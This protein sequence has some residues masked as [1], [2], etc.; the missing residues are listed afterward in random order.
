MSQTSE[1]DFKQLVD[2]IRQGG[3]VNQLTSN[4]T[5]EQVIQ[6]RKWLNPYGRAP[7]ATAGKEADMPQVIVSL[8]NL[9][10]QYMKRFLMTSLIGF[11]Y[12]MLDEWELS[13]DEPVVPLDDFN[14]YMKTAKEAAKDG[15]AS[16]KWLADNPEPSLP[17]PDDPAAQELKQQHDKWHAE[18]LRHR[19]IIER[20]SGYSR[21]IVAR[22][23]IDYL[24]QFNPDLHVRSAYASNPLDPERAPIS[25]VTPKVPLSENDEKIEED[26]SKAF[27]AFKA[28]KTP[29]TP[30]SSHSTRHIPPADVFHRWTYYSDNNFEEIRSAVTDIYADKP[31]FEYAVLPYGEF[32]NKEEADKFVNKHRDEVIADL[33]TLTKGKWNLMGAFKANRERINFYNDKTAVVE[34]LLKQVEED[35]KLG[36]DLMRKRVER[37]KKKNIAEYGPDDAEFLERYRKDQANNQAEQMG[38]EDVARV[39]VKSKETHTFAVHEECPY[40]A[41]QVDVFDMMD[42]GKTVKKSEFFTQAETPQVPDRAECKN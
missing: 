8:I 28:S 36:A 38:A 40:D 11:L 31:D 29:K 9:K 3:D 34:A 14:E 2:S 10:E 33:V 16:R 20:D 30:N 32:S 42:G 6:M 5:D 37:V 1:A 12:K 18:A 41:V 27:K 4:L 7:T 15:E 22:Q 35:K 13:R 39:G 24:F 21:R 17:E 19:R 26:A 25:G 23:F